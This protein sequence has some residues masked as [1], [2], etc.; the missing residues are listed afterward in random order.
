MAYQ[1]H[2]CN[3]IQY[4]TF[5]EDFFT[6]EIKVVEEKTVSRNSIALF[7]KMKNRYQL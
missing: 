1:Y 4:E 5:H 7:M 2:F 3:L 6:F